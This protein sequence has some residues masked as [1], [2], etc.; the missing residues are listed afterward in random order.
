MNPESAPSIPVGPAVAENTAQ[1]QP[2]TTSWR[3]LFCL[4]GSPRHPKHRQ[5]G[6]EEEAT[7]VDGTSHNQRRRRS[8]VKTPTRGAKTSNGFV[9]RWMMTE[10][11]YEEEDYEEVIA[12]G[13]NEEFRRIDFLR[14]SPPQ[15]RNRHIDEY[16]GL[17]REGARANVLRLQT[18]PQ[19][20]T[21][22]PA[23]TMSSTTK[24]YKFFLFDVF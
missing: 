9:K 6:G 21:I 7:A 4:F 16:E 24:I 18:S 3:L 20:K 23:T 19:C 2:P 14:T 12:A 1:H 22:S 13:N 11:D 17:E 10:E 8:S 15:R 5:R